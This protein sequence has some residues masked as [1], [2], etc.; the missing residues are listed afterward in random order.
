[1]HSHNARDRN[2][3]VFAVCHTASSRNAREAASLAQTAVLSACAM[4]YDDGDDDDDTDDNQD[5]DA[6]HAD[7]GSDDGEPAGPVG[8]AMPWSFMVL[9]FSFGWYTKPCSALTRA[10]P[11][12]LRIQSLAQEALTGRTWSGDSPAPCGQDS[13]VALRTRATQESP[14]NAMPPSG[15]FGALDSSPTASTAT[16]ESPSGGILDGCD[17]VLVRTHDKQLASW[18]VAGVRR[19]NSEHQV[20]VK[21]NLSLLCCWLALK[22]HLSIASTG[23]AGTKSWNLCKGSEH[24]LFH[25]TF[26]L[27]WE[28]AFS[29]I[30]HTSTNEF[31]GARPRVCEV[32]LPACWG[33]QHGTVLSQTLAVQI[34][35]WPNVADCPWLHQLH[36]LTAPRALLRGPQAGEPRCSARYLESVLLVAW[37]LPKVL[38]LG[39]SHLWECPSASPWCGPKSWT[40][41]LSRTGRAIVSGFSSLASSFL[42]ASESSRFCRHIARMATLTSTKRLAAFAWVSVI[43]GK[44]TF[45]AQVYASVVTKSKAQHHR[46]W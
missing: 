6:E 42:C 4:R 18:R 10:G 17:A 3:Y 39:H 46:A 33:E 20:I 32:L 31:R 2:V 13:S 11:T 22:T 45:A 24:D 8:P 29:L 16:S 38:A 30:L 44:V 19:R 7:D 5:G 35:V 27:F 43:F 25:L 34:H 36:P 21:Q 23:R 40:E 26:K 14:H 28:V 12:T 15:V 37:A 9:I 41:Y 1:M